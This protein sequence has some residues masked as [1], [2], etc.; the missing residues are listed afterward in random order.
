MN[1]KETRAAG[2]ADLAANTSETSLKRGKENL[3]HEQRK[4]AHG[5]H[6]YNQE[7]H[8]RLRGEKL[9]AQKQQSQVGEVILRKEL[10]KEEQSI[11]VP[12]MHEEVVIERRTMDDEPLG[13]SET[14]RI[15]VNAEQVNVTKDTVTIGDVVI[16]KRQVEETR[17]FKDTVQHEE[18]RLEREGEI[19][20]WDTGAGK[21]PPMQPGAH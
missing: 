9:H 4:P 15:P 12:V 19:P 10:V 2:T 14:I 17:H 7:Q 11:D 1:P 5:E 6:E 18:A 3:P 8:M 20:F 13:A 16:G 21:Q